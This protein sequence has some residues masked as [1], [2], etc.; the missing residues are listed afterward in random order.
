MSEA[1]PLLRGARRAGWLNGI[2]K[3]P[4]PRNTNQQTYDNL[5]V[6]V[7]RLKCSV[8]KIYIPALLP[9]FFLTQTF[10]VLKNTYLC[11]DYQSL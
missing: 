5:V 6:F 2:T 8:L 7:N 11:V 1:I 9:E 10:F 4:H 3:L